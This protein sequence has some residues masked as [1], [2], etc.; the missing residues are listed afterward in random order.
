MLFE[1]AK[2]VFPG[3]VNSPA[4]ALKHLP[5]PLVAKA[6]SGAYLYTDRGK[7]VDYCMAF[8]AIIL[9]HA[10]PRV[11][12][13][14]E[15]Q[16]E[17]GWIYALLTEQE[18][19]FA[20]RIRR[21]MPSVEKMR[22]VNTGTEATMSAIRAARGY[23]KRDVII[24]FEGN[25][26]GSHDYVLVK[27]GSGAATWGIPTSAG[28]PQEVAR[29]T[30]VVPYNDIDAFIKAVR[31]VGDRLA[32]VIVEP[33][34]GNYGLIIP[35]VE[36]LKALREETQRAGALLIFDEVITGFR[37]G[38]GG[39][40][41][42]FGIRPDLTTLGKVVGGGFPIGI[43]G[44]RGEVMDLVAPSGPV[45]NA[46]TYNAHPVSIA[47]GLA[48]LKELETGEPYRIANEA[49]ERLAKGVEDVAGRLGFDVVVKRMASMFQ[50]YF[51]KGDVKTPQDV[52]ESNEK[53]YLKLHEIALKHG[54][55][56]TPSQYEVNFTSAAHGREVVEETLAALEKS[57]QEL[58][59]EI[60]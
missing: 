17:K 38:L 44:G 27:A 10:H 52:R 45:Y 29:L 11:K 35:D 40:Q 26:H 49:A 46:G 43:F 15:E 31:E 3:G 47:A 57:F 53:M 6:A 14:V 1:R 55:Y 24:K 21:H 36:F 34:A 28:I 5:S 9:G 32:A 18:V 50:F 7:L 22:I 20:E 42:L 37:V 39:A 30:V 8:G 19:E 56:L 48:V 25:F 58:Q 13:A 23:T 59:R 33:V 41:G 4:R 16:L 2:S 60:G 12:K 51:K 54:V